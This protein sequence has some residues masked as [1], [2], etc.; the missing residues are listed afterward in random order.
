MTREQYEKQYSEGDDESPFSV[1]Q[2]YQSDD[3]SMES[4][5]NRNKNKNTDKTAAND[6]VDRVKECLK[7]LQP[8]Q[9]S[10]DFNIRSTYK[11]EKLEEM[12]KAMEELWLPIKPDISKKD[13]VN[14]M[15]TTIETVLGIE[16]RDEPTPLQVE[17]LMDKSLL[18]PIHNLNFRFANAD[19]IRNDTFAKSRDYESRFQRLFM[20]QSYAGELYYNFT[21]WSHRIKNPEL[22]LNESSIGLLRYLPRTEAD[23]YPDFTKYVFTYNTY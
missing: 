12:L 11:P 18:E 16:E 7:I 19:L 21:L 1:Q 3:S 22:D 8:L 5:C 13:R 4:E 15:V 2:D 10:M 17:T 14:E 23:T 9:E 20:L 6:I